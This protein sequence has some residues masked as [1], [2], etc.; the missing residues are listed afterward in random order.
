MTMASKRPGKQNEKS[1]SPLDE[2]RKALLEHERKLKEQ[3][4]KREHLI[5]EAP[6]LKEEQAKVRREE[7]LKRKARVETG[8]GPRTA[9]VDKR[10]ETHTAATR[11]GPRLKREQRR[12]MLTFFV[13]LAGFACVLAWVYFTL[14]RGF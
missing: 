12:G 4:A 1:A 3:I 6:K 9:L 11:P 2:K 8:A 13:L 14:F 10:Y 7:L 5:R